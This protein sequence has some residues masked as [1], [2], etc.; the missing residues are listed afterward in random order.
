VRVAQRR[1]EPHLALE[2]RDVDR[3]PELRR[4]HLHHDAAPQPHLFGHEHAT[5]PPAAELTLDRVRRAE[6]LA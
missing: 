1:D 6:R 2:A 3:A 5:H 4:Q